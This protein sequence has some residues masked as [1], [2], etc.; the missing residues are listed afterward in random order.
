V[1]RVPAVEEDSIAS[2][3]YDCHLQRYDEP[4]SFLR[5]VKDLGTAAVD[6]DADN[7]LE[8]ELFLFPLRCSVLRGVGLLAAEMLLIGELGKVGAADRQGIYECLDRIAW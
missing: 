1:T 3:V 6:I 5:M 7:P 4:A 2:K 8:G